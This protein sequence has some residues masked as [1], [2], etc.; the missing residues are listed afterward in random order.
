MVKEK[1]YLTRSYEVMPEPGWIS[2][3]RNKFII[4]PRD[5][6]NLSLKVRVPNEPIYFSKKWEE[7]LLVQPDNGLPSFI[8]VKI[9]TRK[10]NVD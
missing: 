5:S 2:L 1:G 4:K 7:I 6:F 3:S 10:E 8:R 9:E